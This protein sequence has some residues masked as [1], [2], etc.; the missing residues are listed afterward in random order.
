MSNKSKNIVTKTGK[1]DGCSSE[2]FLYKTPTNKFYCENCCR[3]WKDGNKDGY[4]DGMKKAFKDI[5]GFET[6]YGITIKD[7]IKKH[8]KK[9][10]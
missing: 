5:K 9:K 3:I 1:C 2:S 6:E 10:D 7:L 8:I 4:K